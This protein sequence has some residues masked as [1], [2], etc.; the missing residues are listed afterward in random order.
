MMVLMRKTLLTFLFL[1]YFLSIA[2]FALAQY[3][4]DRADV[5]TNDQEQVINNKLAGFDQSSPDL[6]IKLI[7]LAT[8]NGET[9]V[10]NA[11]K[12]ISEWQFTKANAILFLVIREGR[13][14]LFLGSEN[15]D[16]IKFNPAANSIINQDM[17]PYFKDGR[18][19]EG[20]NVGTD[21][22]LTYA[23]NPD[24]FVMTERSILAENKEMIMFFA[25]YIGLIMLILVAIIAAGSA[26][27]KKLWG[28]TLTGAVLGFITS[29][30]PG[31]IF[32]AAFGAMTDA[33]W[34][35]V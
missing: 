6:S 12:L 19:S 15:I 7:I 3:V 2:P 26:T 18:L 10:E 33:Y 27:K 20:I 16:K 35:K 21:R 34:R 5:L 31:L 11:E 1:F 22:I 13:Q 14:V 25:K 9:L 29:S 8:N 17:A 24:G 28:G 4:D 23:Q 30:F 32:F